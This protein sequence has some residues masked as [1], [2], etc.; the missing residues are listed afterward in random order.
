M[1]ETWNMI[2]LSL[3]KISH[4]K[5]KSKNTQ[6]SS[7]NAI[8]ICQNFKEEHTKSIP[9]FEMKWRNS[10]FLP[11][12]RTFPNFRTENW[13]RLNA[14][15]SSAILLVKRN[16]SNYWLGAPTAFWDNFTRERERDGLKIYS[17]ADTFPKNLSQNPTDKFKFLDKREETRY[18][19]HYQ[20]YKKFLS[21]TMT[22]H[23]PPI[24]SRL[25]QRKKTKEI[26]FFPSLRR[27][28]QKK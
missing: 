3:I 27:K 19:N 21:W 5:K 25:S 20:N 16:K 18:L 6:S 10:P 2:K 22:P 15:S 7:P 26:T 12:T 14:R 28:E 24:L 13:Q 1:T 4:T 23:Q 17:D 8:Q 9:P 11:T